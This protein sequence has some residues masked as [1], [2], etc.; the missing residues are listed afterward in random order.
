MSF[1]SIITGQIPAN[2]AHAALRFRGA[3]HVDDR[4]DPIVFFGSQPPAKVKGASGPF[5]PLTTGSIATAVEDLTGVSAQSVS[6]E[7]QLVS[8]CG[9]VPDRPAVSF[10]DSFVTGVDC[11]DNGAEFVHKC[12]ARIDAFGGETAVMPNGCFAGIFNSHAF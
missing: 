8:G 1:L 12:K 9:S 10:I 4:S 11:Q 3:A 5:F 6:A 2:A 7:R